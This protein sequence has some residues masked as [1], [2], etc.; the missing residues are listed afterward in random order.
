MSATALT[1]TGRKG[2]IRVAFGFMR[3]REF[4]QPEPCIHLYTLWNKQVMVQIPSCQMYLFDY[5]DRDARTRDPQCMPKC[6]EIAEMLY[7]MPTSYGATR[8]LDAI[9][10][11]MDDIKNMPPP[12]T[13]R[14]PE[15]LFE[16]MKRRGFDVVE[17]C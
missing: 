6:A 1:A 15:M 17:E 16:E 13:F 4:A 2:D 7:G 12:S 14:N 3:V 5:R 9:T 11:W 10:D 8:V